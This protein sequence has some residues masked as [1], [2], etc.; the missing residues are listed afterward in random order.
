MA[1][2]EGS[3]ARFST[4]VYCTAAGESL[5]HLRNWTSLNHGLIKRAARDMN[6]E[7]R[8]PEFTNKAR[9][10]PRNT[11]IEMD[12]PTIPHSYK[13]LGSW[14]RY[15]KISKQWDPKYGAPKLQASQQ[16]TEDDDH[17]VESILMCREGR[18]EDTSPDELH[19]AVRWE[20]RHEQQHSV[21]AGD[22]FFSDLRDSFVSNQ[23]IRLGNG[24]FISKELNKS[25]DVEYLIQLAVK[26]EWPSNVMAYIRDQLSMEEVQLESGDNGGGIEPDSECNSCHRCTHECLGIEEEEEFEEEEEEAAGVEE[27][28]DVKFTEDI[29]EPVLVNAVITTKEKKVVNKKVAKVKTTFLHTVNEFALKQEPELE[30]DTSEVGNEMKLEGRR[31]A[32]F[33]VINSSFKNELTLKEKLLLEKHIFNATF[34]IAEK[35]HILCSWNKDLFC[36]IYKSLARSVLANFISTNYTKNESLFKRYKAGIVQLE[37]IPYLSFSDLYPEIW[38]DLS[39]R[40]FEREKRQ[41]EGN[42]AMATDQ[43]HCKGCG[44]RECT[45]YELQTR[46][47]DEPMTIFIQCVNCGKHWRL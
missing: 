21:V 20:G 4:I 10:L 40:Q 5:N 2:V 33:E 38:K 31:L 44:K 14:H 37:E 28:S 8:G 43:F 41:L 22:Q 11:W 29:E 34:V 25:E 32:L 42:K 39:M 46:S 35:K 18:V 26:E 16:H 6:P 9:R 1:D 27:E 13:L 12:T 30:K 17:G 7:E 47:A 19:Y 15:D 23:S 3:S 36:E 45:Y 24:Y